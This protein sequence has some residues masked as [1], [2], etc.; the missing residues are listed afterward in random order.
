MRGAHPRWPITLSGCTFGG[1]GLVTDEVWR[2]FGE[3]NN[4]VEPFVGSGAVLLSRPEPFHGTETIGD[5]DGF[6]VNVWRALK[7]APEEVAPY[8]MDPPNSFDMAARRA[9]LTLEPDHLPKMLMADPEAFDAR[10]AGFWLYNQAC[11]LNG[12]ASSS[13]RSPTPRLWRNGMGV[14]RYRDDGLLLADLLRIRDRL[15]YVRMVHGDWKRTVT[16]SALQSHGLS[17]VFFDPPY[18]V[19]DRYELYSHDSRSVS[20]EVFDWAIENQHDPN[21]RLAVCGYSGEHNFPDCWEVFKWT[22]HGFIS[23]AGGQGRINRDR[24]R[25]WFSPS[26]LKPDTLTLW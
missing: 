23:N 12:V 20:H 8:V 3:V 4:V 7:H 15:R 11:W 24:E 21:L 16:L 2:R 6:L 1:K 22:S 13:T 14:V 17:A 18:G 26:C 10:L 9:A 19:E 25:I 5:L